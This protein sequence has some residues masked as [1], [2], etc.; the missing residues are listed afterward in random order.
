MNGMDQFILTN[1]DYDNAKPDDSQRHLNAETSL[2]C[3]E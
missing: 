2:L 1:S 3:M